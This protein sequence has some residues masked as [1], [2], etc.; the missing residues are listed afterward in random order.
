MKT[1]SLFAGAGGLDMGFKN[2]GF[3]IVWA[4]DI[5]KDAC[6]TH[7]GWSDSVI[8]NEDI[9]NISIN[10]LPDVEAILGGFP[11]QGFSLAGPRK[12]Y[13]SRNLL[14]RFYV[15]AV[16]EKKPAIFVAENVKGILTLGGG[17]VIKKIK[18]DFEKAGDGYNVSVQKV[19]SSDYGVAQDRVRVFIIGIS[20]HFK[21]KDTFV[22]NEALKEKV[23]LRDILFDSND[24]E[25]ED[26]C[27]APYSSRFMSRNRKRDW[28]EFSYTIPAMAKQVTLH[29]SSPDMIKLGKNK[30]IFG[31][32]I[33]RRYTWREA[34][35]VQSF[36]ADL[37]FY[38]DMVSKYRQIGNAV[39]VKLAEKIGLMINDYIAI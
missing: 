32:G 9:K 33:T 26:L 17:E 28:D 10:S 13:D 35:L 3:E 5:N 16:N 8:V 20:K 18:R 25:E 31:E 29:P 7:K 27:T 38:G 24:F 19:N 22:I 37:E 6:E 30:W 36:P 34:A 14:Y 2:A 21:R 23:V 39:P 4:N 15:E 1:L 12:V 11:C